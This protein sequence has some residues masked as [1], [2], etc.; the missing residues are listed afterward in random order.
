MDITVNKLHTDEM[1]KAE[2]SAML[3][4]GMLLTL[5]MVERLWLHGSPYVKGGKVTT[6]DLAC[7]L[8]IVPHGDMGIEDFHNALVDAL[9]TAWRAYEII[10]PD[11]KEENGKA[12]EIEMFSPEWLA[13][14]VSQACHSMPSLT[15]QQV[16]WEAPL[17][18]VLHLVVSQA[19]RN[20]A[21]TR[22]PDDIMEALRRLKEL[23]KERHNG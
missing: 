1:V 19:R 18:L 11:K 8:A 17:A 22:R 10:V 20:G 12:S 21:I 5:G 9:T 16:L 14:T 15:V 2:V 13:E 6:D 4:E 23:N 7:A 3:G